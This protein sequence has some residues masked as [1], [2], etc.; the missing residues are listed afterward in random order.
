MRVK[1]RAGD[2][3]TEVV[4][5]IIITEAVA[6]AEDKEKDKGITAVPVKPTPKYDLEKHLYNSHRHNNFA[7]MAIC[8]IAKEA[9][10]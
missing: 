7:P 4:D 5:A 3:V 6:V 9:I 8:T 2:S 1:D 10:R